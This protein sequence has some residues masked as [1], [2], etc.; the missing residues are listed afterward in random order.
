[1]CVCRGP[2]KRPR[3]DRAAVTRM[4]RKRT[5][6]TAHHTGASSASVIPNYESADL[7]R[8][9]LLGRQADDRLRRIRFAIIIAPGKLRPCRGQNYVPVLGLLLSERT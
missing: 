4:R 3:R 8:L 7:V 6:A 9:K 1:M 5:A 2:V